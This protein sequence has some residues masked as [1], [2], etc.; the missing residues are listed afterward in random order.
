MPPMMLFKQG[1][2]EWAFPCAHLLSMRLLKARVNTVEIDSRIDLFFSNGN[3]SIF[4]RSLAKLWEELVIGRTEPIVA[5]GA[6]FDKDY[7]VKAFLFDVPAAEPEE[8]TAN[9]KK[10]PPVPGEKT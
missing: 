4:G 8:A 9:T 7:K 10:E 2:T 3:V 6:A 5:N 1:E